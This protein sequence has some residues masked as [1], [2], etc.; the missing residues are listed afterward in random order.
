MLLLCLVAD[1]VLGICHGVHS[2]IM[3]AEIH[4]WIAVRMTSVSVSRS[5]PRAAAVRVRPACFGPGRLR[6]GRYLFITAAAG[7]GQR[8]LEGSERWI[9][10]DM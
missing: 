5:R 7:C 8:G 2:P 9:V 10:Y 3:G 4:D 6:P 1:G